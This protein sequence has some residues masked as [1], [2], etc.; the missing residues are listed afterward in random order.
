M[1]MQQYNQILSRSGWAVPLAICCILCTLLIIA[2]TIILSL[3]PVYVTPKDINYNVLSNKISFYTI[4]ASDMIDGRSLT[5]S[6]TD[7]L[8]LQMEKN[9]PRSNK[10]M[11]IK[12]LRFLPQ[13]VSTRSKRQTS[14][15]TIICEQN[16]GLT[17]DLFATNDEVQLSSTCHSSNCHQGHLEKSENTIRNNNNRITVNMKSTDNK[18][19]SVNLAFCGFSTTDPYDRITSASKCTSETSTYVYLLDQDSNLF[20]FHPETFTVTFIAMINCSTTAYPY[21]MAIQRNGTAWVLFTDGSLYTFNVT[22]VQCQTTTYVAEQEGLILF[23]MH[24]AT[25][26]S[27]NNEKLYLSSDS[28]NPPF[29]LATLDIDTLEISIIGY[30][31]TISARA[32]LTGTNDGKL[33]GLFEGAP[34]VI[35]EI[36]RT[37]GEILSKTSQDMIQYT[38]DSSNFAFTTYSSNFFLFVGDNSFTDIFIYNLSTKITTKT[39]RISNGIVGS[40]VSTCL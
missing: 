19:R 10:M 40:A 36:N 34:Y 37:N 5:L 38:S 33:F 23:G 11:S 31:E 20:Q 24:F 26:G 15:S 16:T 39:T 25:D 18:T 1:L 32:E 27:N 12:S 2:G 14:D 9:I 28:S 13:A 29:R 3:I 8:S 21:S 6:D 22:N 30:Y 17:G 4:Y 35:A 7:D